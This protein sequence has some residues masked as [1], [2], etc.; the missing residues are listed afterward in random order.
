MLNASLV[1]LSCLWAVVFRC[2]P[3]LLSLLL[4]YIKGCWCKFNVG[5]HFLR[6][7]VW[8]IQLS[9]DLT[10]KVPIPFLLCLVSCHLPHSSTWN[11]KRLSVGFSVLVALCRL[12]PRKH[13]SLRFLFVLKKVSL[14]LLKLSLMSF[15]SSPSHSP[16]LCSVL[17]ATLGVTSAPNSCRPRAACGALGPLSSRGIL[18]CSSSCQRGFSSETL[19]PLCS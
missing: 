5:S 19:I 4:F 16:W 12:L 13:P 14:A 3:P 2:W 17:K 1:P 10:L 8:H 15:Q 6:A 11:Q 7:L 9:R 18:G